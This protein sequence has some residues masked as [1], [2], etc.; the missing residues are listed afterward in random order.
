MSFLTCLAYIIALLVGVLA[1]PPMRP[2]LQLRAEDACGTYRSDDQVG[3]LWLNPTC[4]NME[5]FPVD[6]TRVTNPKCQMCM[7]FTL[8]GFIQRT[9][10]L[11]DN[12]TGARP[13]LGMSSI[14]A[15]SSRR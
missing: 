4:Q 3:T 11:A 2:E 13:A 15:V 14:L 10:I 12:T 5:F 8:V 9:R 6:A 7:L 1:A